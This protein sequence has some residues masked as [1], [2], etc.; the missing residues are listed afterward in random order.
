MNRIGLEGRL[1]GPVVRG[2]TT[3]EKY[4]DYVD[5]MKAGSLDWYATMRSL[6]RQKRKKEISGNLENEKVSFDLI[7]TD[8]YEDDILNSE[9]VS[10]DDETENVVETELVKTKPVETKFVE[11]VKIASQRYYNGILP[12]SNYPAFNES[13][14]NLIE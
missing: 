8:L 10:L 12:S 1:G 2:V 9:I 13:R 5:E 14:V 6:Y 3:R 4:L 7:P 11:E